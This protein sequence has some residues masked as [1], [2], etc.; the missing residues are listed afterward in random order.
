MSNDCYHKMKPPHLPR[1]SILSASCLSRK[2]PASKINL[3]L[4]TTKRSR[5]FFFPSYSEKEKQIL[6]WMDTYKAYGKERV[7]TRQH[8]T[9]L[10]KN[11]CFDMKISY[12]EYDSLSFTSPMFEYSKASGLKVQF[13]CIYTKKKKKKKKNWSQQQTKLK[14][15]CSKGLTNI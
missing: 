3:F 7:T 6:T 1:Q 9:M 10:R 4:H 15:V 11:N 13:I 5:G 12:T 14:L 8:N 2:H